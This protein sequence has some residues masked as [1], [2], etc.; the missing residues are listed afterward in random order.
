MEEFEILPRES[1]QHVV[2]IH[3]VPRVI[4]WWFATKRKNI[5]FG[6][7]YRQFEKHGS[8]EILELTNSKDAGFGGSNSK[9]ADGAPDPQVQDDGDGDIPARMLKTATAGSRFNSAQGRRSSK[10]RDPLLMP[11]LAMNHVESSKGTIKGQ[12]NAIWP[13][14]Y[15]LY[16]D[17]SF[18]V[19]TSKILSL[20]VAINEVAGP[21][22]SAVQAPPNHEGWLQKKKRKRMQGYAQR[23]VAIRGAYLT[24]STTPHG[25]VRAKVDIRNAVVTTTAKQ[26][27]IYIDS[28]DGLM[29]FRS[30]SDE[31]FKEWVAAINRAKAVT[32]DAKRDEGDTVSLSD[33]IAPSTHQTAL[34]TAPLAAPAIHSQNDPA[35]N[36]NITDKTTTKDDSQPNGAQNGVEESATHVHD[37]YLAESTQ[38]L[39][40]I[41]NIFTILHSH[42][43]ESS[44]QLPVQAYAAAAA[45]PPPPADGTKADPASQRELR[46]RPSFLEKLSNKGVQNTA[47]PLSDN[48]LFLKSLHQLRSC[49][50]NMSMFEGAL[51]TMVNDQ[52]PTPISHTPKSKICEKLDRALSPM[53]SRLS[54]TE[55]EVFYDTYEVIEVQHDEEDSQSTPG[56]DEDRFKSTAQSP[57]N[58]D[59][60][61]PKNALSTSDSK[62]ECENEADGDDS[63]SIDMEEELSHDPD[64]KRAIM[65][66]SFSRLP[67]QQHPSRSSTQYSRTSTP[68]SPDMFAIGKPRPK[69]IVRRKTLPS[70]MVPDNSNILSILRNNLGKDLS[71][72]TMPIT[73][74]EPINAL[75]LL[76]EELQYANLL[77]IAGEMDDSLDRLTYVTAFVISG[78]ASK[79][80]RSGRKPFNPLLGETYEC[81]REDLGFRFV[82]EKVSHH[83][84]VMACHA[85]SQHFE[86]WQDSQIK[87]KFWG[88]SLELVP[89]AT[90]HIKIPKYGD[91]YTFTKPSTLVRGLITGNRTVEMNGE[92]VITNQK[93]NDSATIVFKKGGLFSSASN[94]VECR[95]Y[96]SPDKACDRLLH[97]DWTS[98]IY[99]AHNPEEPIWKVN[100]T[101]PDHKKYYGFDQ[102]A[103]E[104][105]E[106]T[107]D[108]EQWLPPT[109]TRFRPDQRLYEKGQVDKAE[110]VKVQ[111]EQA[112][113]ERREEMRQSGHTWT[114]QYFTLD[115]NNSDPAS[116]QGW[117]YKGGY[118]E[119]REK[120]S[121]APKVQLWPSSAI[122]NKS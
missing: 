38:A 112:Q 11:L 103:I 12:W 85:H 73:T 44:A 18:S 94:Q 34:P 100:P 50:H 56:S 70:P 42:K 28:D 40:I 80:I 48:E 52:K 49:V 69:S 72:I 61:S 87:T 62:V 32:D 36:N 95:L 26:R 8:T 9:Q 65:S 39:A 119:A 29:Q 54:R 101:P 16:F 4:S 60:A 33:S 98:H 67:P 25:V 27:V 83:P 113:R 41:T 17:N 71:T 118:W 97:G 76:C 2:T 115:S 122:G 68:K 57:I 31:G 102:F 37:R 106:L 14:T 117:V 90:V 120:R 21:A 66:G 3:E 6:L 45:P 74:N 7:F 19:N 84:A 47:N 92:V 59:L 24:Y 82:S 89:I 81:V 58:G 88:K 93:T 75:Q 91:Y 96:T 86:M 5:D 43:T 116:N 110:Q 114:P 10:L 111:L 78:L 107:E 108:I 30:N 64:F 109:D 104:L 23:W 99:E 77:N 121:F 105:N 53:S 51:Y 20:V 46:K 35:C 1:Y 55:S 63:S 22:E 13:G 79:A 15:I